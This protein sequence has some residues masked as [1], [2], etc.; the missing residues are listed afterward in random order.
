MAIR[1]KL[2]IG[3]YVSVDSPVHRMNPSVKILLTMVFMI[4][5]FMAAG[6]GGIGLVT[7]FLVLV[8]ALSRIKPGYLVRGLKPVLFLVFFTFLLHLLFT[9]EG[10]N[11]QEF[12]YVKNEPV[13]TI[14]L[15]LEP[16]PDSVKVLINKRP[17][18][19]DSFNGWTL[20][21]SKVRLNGGVVPKPGDIVQVDYQVG[22]VWWS[23]GIIQVTRE[24]VVNGVR[25]FFR[26]VLL[27]V[28]A[29]LLTL[30]T[31]P[32]ELTDGLET[33][34]KPLAPIGFPA[35]EFSMM[36][37]IALRFIPVLLDELDRIMKAQKSRGADFET[38]GLVKRAKNLVP[39]LVP[40]FVSSF[41]RAE[42]LA[43]AM[44]VRCYRGGEGRTRMRVREISWRDGVGA[45]MV[46]VLGIG[47]F[48]L[49]GR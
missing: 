9:P 7:G 10:G 48:M 24:G 17:V 1:D 4:I 22:D 29:T 14:E 13:L 26:L 39:L 27:V 36:M 18:R 35:H 37:T 32:I 12:R 28:A 41:K 21:G 38:G 5:I 15:M 20:Q 47:L 40:L 45:L 8:T 19:E 34:F 44:E 25:I 11:R 23:L 49:G 3:Q 42:E 2:L 43:Q 46:V 6:P 30:T 33:L 16:N 31:S